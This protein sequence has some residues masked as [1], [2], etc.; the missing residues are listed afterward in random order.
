[1]FDDGG[2]NFAE[3]F[4]TGAQEFVEVRKGVR[5]SVLRPHFTICC[6][7]LTVTDDVGYFEKDRLGVIEFLHELQKL[8]S[9]NE[10]LIAGPVHFKVLVMAFSR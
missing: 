7:L 3:L 1:V 8:I 9:A 6:N 10:W 5:R 4:G 2:G